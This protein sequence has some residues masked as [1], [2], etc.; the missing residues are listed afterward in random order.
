MHINIHKSAPMSSLSLQTVAT[1]SI[2]K[3]E[4][5]TLMS[6]YAWDSE[7]QASIHY[8]FLASSSGV[9]PLSWW[10]ER[11]MEREGNRVCA[12]SSVGTHGV[13]LDTGTGSLFLQHTIFSQ[14]TEISRAGTASICGPTEAIA[15]QLCEVQPFSE[16]DE[17]TWVKL[18]VKICHVSGHVIAGKGHPLQCNATHF[19][20]VL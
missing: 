10:T 13:L 7:Q 12:A 16:K 8:C 14:Q 19:I 6:A 3:C 18:W 20:L 9:N 4:K 17:A 1:N 2:Q 5:H 11:Q 15:I